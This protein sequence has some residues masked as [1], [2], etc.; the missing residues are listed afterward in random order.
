MRPNPVPERRESLTRTHAHAYT[1]THAHTH[2]QLFPIFCQNIH[3]HKTPLPLP[4]PSYPIIPILSLF[5]LTLFLQYWTSHPT[6]KPTP[7]H[8]YRL[9]FLREG[10]APFKFKHQSAKNSTLTRPACTHARDVTFQLLCI[11]Y[12]TLFLYSPPTF[13]FPLTSPVLYICRLEELVCRQG[14]IQC[15]WHW[16]GGADWREPALHVGYCQAL[17]LIAQKE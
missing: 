9:Y 14:D 15:S 11:L 12:S 1:R 2:C 8:P 7:F 10:V 16:G 5:F 6:F 13:F 3:T 17:S 4:T